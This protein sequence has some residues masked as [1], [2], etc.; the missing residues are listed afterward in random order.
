MRLHG[1]IPGRKHLIVSM[2]GKSKVCPAFFAFIFGVGVVVGVF[3][4]EAT[5]SQHADGDRT[6]QQ[7]SDGVLK[8]KDEKPQTDRADCL[9]AEYP[10]G[11]GK[12]IISAGVLNAK[13][14]DIPKPKYP[15]SARRK[16]IGG[17]VKASVFID[18]SGKVAWARVDNGNQLLRGAVKKVVCRAL[19]KRATISGHPYSFTGLITYRFVPKAR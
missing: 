4:C 3:C 13:A 5:F 8:T 19:F 10:K 1:I 14:L 18:E 7:T 11:K 16:K 9:T 12:Y 2:K 17:E 15:V 6:I